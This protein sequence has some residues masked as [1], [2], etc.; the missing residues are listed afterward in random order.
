MAAKGI[1]A[2]IQD[3]EA[4]NQEQFEKLEKLSAK[5]QKSSGS[6]AKLKLVEIKKVVS[7]IEDNLKKSDSLMEKWD[8]S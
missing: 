6:K 8:A 4:D 1:E 5:A 2:K 3:I 7:K